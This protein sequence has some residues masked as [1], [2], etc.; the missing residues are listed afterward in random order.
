[1]D[2]LTI[3]LILSVLTFTMVP[4]I[5]AG[6]AVRMKLSEI[7]KKGPWPQASSELQYNSVDESQN[8]QPLHSSNMSLSQALMVCTCLT[9]ISSISYDTELWHS[10]THSSGLFLLAD[11]LTDLSLEAEPEWGLLLIGV[12]LA[13]ATKYCSRI[14]T[15]IKGL[16][17][18]L[19]CA[20]CVPHC[21]LVFWLNGESGIFEKKKRW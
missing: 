9:L 1:M 3:S 10:S 8:W 6:T 2:G 5:P 21:L 15:A 18:A 20:L 12:D 16:T 4:N 13:H 17:S 7:W 11:W 19:L 14:L